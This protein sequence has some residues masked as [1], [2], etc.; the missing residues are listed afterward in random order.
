MRRRMM[1]QKGICSLLALLLAFSSLM[2]LPV[3]AAGEDGGS[4][5]AQVS[6]PE[7]T[8]DPEPDPGPE[9]APAD[10]D[11]PADE[12]GPEETGEPAEDANSGETN[13]PAEETGSEETAGPAD[14]TGSEETG[15]PADETGSEETGSPADETGSEETGAEDVTDPDEAD[16]TADETGKE[17]DLENA[18]ESGNGDMLVSDEQ[19]AEAVAK[20]QAMPMLFSV[21]DRGPVYVEN[22]T[23]VLRASA[24]YY[25]EMKFRFSSAS[26]KEFILRVSSP[27]QYSLSCNG[28]EIQDSR[29]SVEVT[30]PMENVTATLYLPL[31]FLADQGISL[32]RQDSVTLNNQNYSLS[33]SDL[34][35]ERAETPK[36]EA[37]D[38]ELGVSA[39]GDGST[40]ELT[41]AAQDWALSYDMKFLYSGGL[42][43]DIEDTYVLSWNKD[44]PKI[45]M[46]QTCPTWEKDLLGA[47]QHP[48]LKGS[49]EIGPQNGG[50]PPVSVLK[51]S[52]GAAFLIDKKNFTFTVGGKT[53]T[54]EELGF[55]EKEE[56]LP[57]YEGIEIDGKF[58]DWAGVP[59]RATVY[60]AGP[61]SPGTAVHCK[62][63]WDG[64]WVYIYFK[65]DALQYNALGWMG[66]HGNGKFTITTDQGKS[67]YVQPVFE[68]GKVSVYGVDNALIAL[69]NTKDTTNVIGHEVEIAV[70][71]SELPRYNKAIDFQ[72]HL[73][74]PLYGGIENLHPVAPPEID[75]SL[76]KCDG[77]YD[78]WVNYPHDLIEYTT[79]GSQ[80]K[81]VDGEIALW[82]SKG[83]LYGHSQSEASINL[84][85]Y[86]HGLHV[87][88][89]LDTGTRVGEI[90][91]RYCEEV[92]GVL[93]QNPDWYYTEGTRMYY[94]VDENDWG[95]DGLTV[96]QMKLQADQSRA[97][98]GEGNGVIMHNYGIAYITIHRN[99]AGEV[100]A[101]ES[102]FALDMNELARRVDMKA[103]DVKLVHGKFGEIGDEWTRCAG[104]PTGSLLGLALCF[105]TV[106]GAYAVDRK[107]KKKK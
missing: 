56:P 86:D 92:N 97:G 31:D 76:F 49:L 32:C 79:A 73:G 105:T 70:P 41:I 15:N 40:I 3:L 45:T 84:R 106:G 51:L 64:E 36:Q 16:G 100:Y 5:E 44:S 89:K 87:H 11:T 8:P 72:F 102:E 27:Q 67:V 69:D 1:L 14:E 39:T 99:A 71:T 38:G 80:L 82:S 68:N 91:L 22:D 96:D 30:P 63:I 78:E 62:M 77:I 81:V 59:H 58:D 95:V 34:P 55:V 25:L 48:A 74:Q 10:N 94:V 103:D 28:P 9:P 29:I 46:N 88:L 24:A 47:N 19:L 26:D 21:R 33:D 52:I 61:N 37:D 50:T 93:T 43:G 13:A 20:L 107:K 98:K 35:G 23:L 53:F 104:T 60:N 42:D 101:A 2:A 65:T 7:T 57:P 85:P 83:I 54:S 4:D 75:Y 18:D 6:E 90:H 17:N 12:S 66:T